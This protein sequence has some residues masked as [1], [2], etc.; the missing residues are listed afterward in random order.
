MAHRA[1]LWAGREFPPFTQVENA[2]RGTVWGVPRRHVRDGPTGSGR[3]VGGEE[4]PP[5]VTCVVA[6]G[7]GQVAASCRAAKS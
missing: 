4:A 1:P 6:E 7:R 3:G 5:G 2:P